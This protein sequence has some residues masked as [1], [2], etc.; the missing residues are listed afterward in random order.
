MDLE[1]YGVW[2]KAGPE[3]VTDE[4]E[5]MFALSD[6]ADDVDESS[7][8]DERSL[9][10][11]EEDLLASLE[12]EDE[13]TDSDDLERA[14]ALERESAEEISEESFSF[15]DTGE[16]LDE[17][18]S[19][20][21]F[22][23]DDIESELEVETELGTDSA[24]SDD[25]EFSIDLDDDE[26]TIDSLESADAEP[27][28]SLSAH[29]DEAEMSIGDDEIIDIDIET[30][31]SDDTMDEISESS[32][33]VEDQGEELPELDLD[34][35][36]D[37]VEAVTAEM[38]AEVPSE[39]PEP[40]A[41]AGI[42]TELASIKSELQALKQ[43]LAELR[44][45][46]PSLPQAVAGTQPV[47][48]PQIDAGFFEED[49][50][51]TI[52]LTG[53]E[54]DNILN[55]A[56][57]TEELGQPSEVDD[58]DLGLDAGTSEDAE[59]ADQPIDEIVLEE[60]DSEHGDLE[61]DSIDLDS[62]L[63]ML[64]DTLS[65]GDQDEEITLHSGED[66]EAELDTD[67]LLSEEDDDA[68]SMMDEPTSPFSGSQD[69]VQELADMDIDSELAGIEELS[70]EDLESPF[71]VDAF[72]ST[73]TL[74]EGL[75][76]DDDAPESSDED[77]LVLNLDDDE[78]IGALE[79]SADDDDDD[80]EEALSLD[81]DEDD[82]LGIDLNSDEGEEAFTFGEEV[83]TPSFQDRESMAQSETE[84]EAASL[85][86]D[87]RDEIRSVLKYMDQLL[88]SLPEEKIEEFARSEHFDV[89]KRL[90]EELGLES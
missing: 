62:G 2:V 31:P 48:E 53:D 51:E 16:D 43:E 23:L 59:L 56:E 86:S 17:T 71:A 75:D 68:N 58:I 55:T 13:L 87:L 65:P 85:P 11:E 33:A 24:S 42:E 37:D 29:L 7:F 78:E 5:E 90:F 21:D 82:D 45:G 3:D 84:N 60:M 22:S 74:E 26:F 57:F 30:I 63:S 46:S 72:S 18:L 4:S 70:D 44:R 10:S 1:Q 15:D 89:Y 64:D 38:L 50:D 9:T 25:E 47:E 69:A 20:D 73:D 41:L 76:L 36:F 6:V 32:F 12:E 14:S 83:L 54:L 39:A 34:E 28:A 81:E 88:E 35:E 8:D 80:V 40:E 19:L 79:L 61:L 66:D 49:E 52:A 27:S 67:L 77:T